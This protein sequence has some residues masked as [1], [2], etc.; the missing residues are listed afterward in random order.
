MSSPTLIVQRVEA[1]PRC[2][3]PT[4]VLGAQIGEQGPLHVD[5]TLRSACRRVVVDPSGDEAP[6]RVSSAAS[7]TVEECDG[8]DSQP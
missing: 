2:G 6:W 1:C 7:A 8:R 3:E 4:P 5:G